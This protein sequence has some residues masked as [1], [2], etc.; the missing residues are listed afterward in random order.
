MQSVTKAAQHALA[1]APCS[2]RALAAQAGVPH[3]TLVRIRA[4]ERDATPEVATALAAALEM[5]A[6][7]CGGAARD[8]RTTLK[9]RKGTT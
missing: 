5:W 2:L 3:T 1:I 6:R 7:E 8:I 9:G 4:G